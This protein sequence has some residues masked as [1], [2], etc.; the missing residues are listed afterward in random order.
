VQLAGDL[1]LGTITILSPRN[2]RLP[3]QAQR[4]RR[5]SQRLGRSSSDQRALRKFDIP[6]R[7]SR[8]SAAHARVTP[9]DRGDFRR[10]IYTSIVGARRS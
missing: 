5:S 9:N 7:R 8:L 3:S 4:F 1:D 10:E 2:R 6:E